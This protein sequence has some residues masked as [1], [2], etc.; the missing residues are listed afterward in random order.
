MAFHF[1][2]IYT[3]FH[4]IESIFGQRDLLHLYENLFSEPGCERA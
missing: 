4:Q 1:A 3:N 2:N